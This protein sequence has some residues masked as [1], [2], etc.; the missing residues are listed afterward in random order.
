MISSRKSARWNILVVAIVAAGL[1]VATL[2]ISPGATTGPKRSSGGIGI[3]SAMADSFRR[4]SS[5]A[6]NTVLGLF[7][8]SVSGNMKTKIPRSERSSV[9]NIRIFAKW[10][11]IERS[12]KG[13]FLWRALDSEVKSALSI[14]VNSIMITLN[15]PVPSWA[16]NK[17]NPSPSYMGP[18][19][20][21]QDWQDF[22]YAVAKR[23]KG[24]VDYFQ[25]W[26]EPG[27]DIDAPAAAD[28]VVYYGGW[29]E[30]S[31]IGLMRAGYQGIKK[32]NPN[33]YACTGSMMNGITRQANDF[34]N[35]EIL[36]AGGNQDISMKIHSANTDIVAERPMY[37]NYHGTMPGGSV[38]LGVKEPQK[39]WYLAEGATHPGFEEWL[40]IQN[41]GNA[42][43]QV[44]ITYMFPNGE[45][46][47]QVVLVP[48]HSRYT[49]DVNSTVGPFKDVSVKLESAQP[50]VVERPM[51]FN[52]HGKWTGGSIDT[53]V[54]EFAKKWYL[55]EGATQPGFEEWISLMNPSASW[56][57]VKITFMFKG[58]ETQV[59]ERK[60]A[61]TS[62]ETVNV[63]EVVGPNR[64]VSALVE[65]NQG[66]IA[67]RPMYFLYHGAWDGGHTQYGS[68]EANKTWL[69]SEGTTRSN[70]D[71]G[72][73]EEWVSIMN[74]GNKEA[75]V[76][77]T[78]MFPGGGTQPGSI[79]VPAHARET[80]LVNNEIGPDKDV[81]V[82]LDSN[83]PIVV[84]RPQYFDY[85]NRIKGGDV[86][87]GCQG[88]ARDWYLAEGT[89]REGFD[90]W[91][92]L[93]NPSDTQAD[94]RITFMFGDSTTQD[95]TV[96]L[97]PKSRTTIG[98]NSS[99]SIA[100]VADGIGIHPYDYPEYWAWYYSYVV[101][102][103]N[104]NG[105]GYREVVVPEI[106]WPHAGRAEFSPE[107]QRGAIGEVGLG[108]LFAAGCK[109]IW[110]F[111]DIDPPQS[112]DDAFN[113]L[114]DI[115]GNAM[116]GWWEYKK[117]Q[118]QL[119]NYGN[120]PNHLW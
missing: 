103:L 62:R 116:P 87:L 100:T 83:E 57:S 31:Y 30:F 113:G 18:P 34:K 58:G 25:V 119:P 39:V 104:K 20:K 37:F 11:L 17:N 42:D 105:Y 99:V 107:G 118:A 94:V 45:T 50:I 6:D 88:G 71:D 44:N 120:K 80:I 55:A 101:N 46:Q 70:P 40:C 68:V 7:S 82:Q 52:Y 61:P 95:K 110:V 43:T 9:R 111:E 64:D 16:E 1:L 4:S 65:A 74:P 22:C 8:E 13:S 117:W 92:T 53:G 75:N 114:F 81:S 15:G 26:L 27:W 67:D 47:P 77:L 78:Y 84:E 115:N 10:K 38:E 63:N 49:I 28:G 32:A 48:G 21:M 86:E 102:I 59:Y 5:L 60:M 69:L 98:V 29:C 35:Y 91:L 79:K 2:L 33:A 108:G 66:I 3:Q 72:A 109:K 90:E 85:H 96:T 51:Y 106:G 93:M 12:R 112:W 24:Y 14:G 36:L 41:P 23:Y 97:P 76:T 56:A 89:T 19:K 54:N 73:F